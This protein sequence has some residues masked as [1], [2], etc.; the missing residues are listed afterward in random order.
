LSSLWVRFV[1]RARWSVAREVVVGLT[2]DLLAD[3]DRFWRLVGHPERLTFTVAAAHA[4]ETERGESPVAGPWGMVERA[5]ARIASAVRRDSTRGIGPANSTPF[6]AAI[7]LMWCIAAASAGR[8]GIWPAMGGAAL[9]LGA[10][11]LVF[12]RAASRDLLRPRA[13]LVLLGL[14]AGAT[15]A[16]ATW[17]LYPLLAHAAPFIGA[18]TR[19]LYSAFRAPSRWGAL[20]ALAPVILGEELVWRSVVQSTVARG[21]GAARGVVLAA[22]LYALAHAP[23]GSPVLVLAALACGLSWGTLRA[24]TGSVVPPLV[25]HVVW[26]VLVLVWLPLDA[27]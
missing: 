27:K 26:D 17:T 19:S 1:T 22:V 24:T 21:F 18:D 3:S 15:M 6:A 10:A 20:L 16:A 11:A 7:V 9:L 4:L 8:I 14:L 12:D 5:R 2:D 23:L 13:E 25:A